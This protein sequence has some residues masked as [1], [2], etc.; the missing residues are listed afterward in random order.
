[1]DVRGDVCKADY[2]EIEKLLPYLDALYVDIKLMDE[3]AHRI[4]TGVSNKK[5]LENIILF[6][7]SAFSAELHVRVPLIPTVNMSEE[8]LLATADFCK[9]LKKISDIELLP[10]HRLG[11]DTYG[12]IGKEYELKEIQPPSG[13]MLYKWAELMALRA[14]GLKIIAGGKEFTS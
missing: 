7:Q 5:I 10:Y 3:E 11:I 14:K 8:N 4:W 13:E 1:M 6:D 9:N 12:K 2:K